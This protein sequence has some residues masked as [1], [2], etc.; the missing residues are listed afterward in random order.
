M[1]YFTWEVRNSLA[2]SGNTD[3]FSKRQRVG[4]RKCQMPLGSYKEGFHHERLQVIQNWEFLLFKKPTCICIRTHYP[5]SQC[6]PF[7]HCQP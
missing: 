7:G 4:R 6:W 3:T 1:K 2:H 5:L